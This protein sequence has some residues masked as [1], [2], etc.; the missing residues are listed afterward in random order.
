MCFDEQPSLRTFYKKKK[1]NHGKREKKAKIKKTGYVENEN[2]PGFHEHLNCCT[3]QSI[4]TLYRLLYLP[5]R[6][7]GALPPSE[8]KEE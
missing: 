4:L 3:T 6:R 5:A 8:Q 1:R 2:E 7:V